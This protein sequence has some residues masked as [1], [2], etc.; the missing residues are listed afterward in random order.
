MHKLDKLWAKTQL[1]SRTLKTMAKGALA[2]TISLAAYQATD[3]AEIYTTLGYL[4]GIISILSFAIMP[5]AKFLQTWIYNVLSACLSAA[6]ALLAIYCAIKARQHTEAQTDTGGATSGSAVG[7]AATVP[8]NSSAA[9][10]CGIWLFFEIWLV[11]TMRARNPQLMIPG[12]I[13]CIFANVSMVYGP[14]FGTMATGI[15][16]VRRL[17]ESFLTGFAIGGAVSLFVFPV[18]MRGVVF[19]EMTG[20]LVSLRKLVAADMAYI[21]SLEETDMFFRADTNIPDRP[22]RSPEAKAVKDLLAALS[23]LHGKLSVDLTFAKREIAYGKLGP[24][25]L[26]AIF[27]HLRGLLQPVS[28][29]SSLVDLFERRAREKHWDHPPP[30]VPL[31]QINDPDE[32][33]RIEAVQDWHAI[34]RAMRDPFDSIAQDI[35]QGFEH[36]LITLQLIKPPKPVS[37]TDAESAGDQPRPGDK[38]FADYHAKKVH[39]FHYQKRHLL[40]KWCS[41]RGIQLTP[42]FFNSP[43]TAEFKAPDWYFEQT[44]SKQRQVYRGRL[45]LVLYMDFLLD[46]IAR[47]VHDFVVFAD[48][49][50]D[51]KMTRKRLIVPGLKRFRKWVISSWSRRQDAYTDEQHGMNDDGAESSNVWLGEAYNKRKDPEHLPARNRIEKIGNRVRHV[52]HFLRSPASAFGF[53]VACA[54]M[55]LAII[56]FLHDT[57]SF[58]VRQRLFWSQIMVT[59]SMSPSAG[60]S[61]F[62]FILRI[63][64]TTAAMITSFIIWYIVDGHTAGVLVFY[65]FFVSW[66]FYIVMKHPRIIPVGMIYC[67]TNTLIIGYELQV[68]KIGV[69]VSETN[70]QAV[71]PIYVLAPYR[72]ATVCAGLFVAWIWTIFPFPISEHSELRRHLGSSLYLLANYYSVVSETVKVRVRGEEL[73]MDDK[74]SPARRLEKMRQVVYSKSLLLIQALRTHSTFTKVSFATHPMLFKREKNKGERKKKAPNLTPT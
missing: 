54:T 66:G 58:Y 45:Y 14:Q 18:T 27:R 3:F 44:M 2:P 30:N 52:A 42:D 12:I 1:D 53:R 41:L 28:G 11:N 61:A 38:A 65:W 40:R 47:A 36:I 63:A 59:I 19:K 64:G 72:L 33:D 24:D 37:S 25:D 71:Y 10:V 56:S 67:V 48:S 55:C 74:R 43:Q 9:A 20:Y 6:V 39:A 5:R 35:D 49:R 73:F 8:Y 60:Q 16:F 26:Q 62:S 31:D 69:A 68:R 50:A 34:M 57:Q 17:L 29:L 46:S 70:G 23:A 22:K 4:V 7:G 21:H 51:S 32:R 13:W 15:R